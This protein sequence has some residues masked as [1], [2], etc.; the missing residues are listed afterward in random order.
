MNLRYH[1]RE[2]RSALRQLRLDLSAKLGSRR[3]AA[4]SPEEVLDRPAVFVLS[5]GRCGTLFLTRLIEAA[6]KQYW[7]EHNP[8][9]IL[10]F[11]SV[12]AFHDDLD[13]AALGNCF[14]AARY[15]SLRK[16]LLAD[17]TYV[18]TNNRLTVYAGGI[19]DVLPN[20]K[21]I[22]LVRHPGDFVR[23]AMRRDFYARDNS[24]ARGHLS[25][26]AGEAAASEWDDLDRVAKCSWLW[27]E[28]NG[29]AEALHD[30]LDG[31]R[32]VTIKSED[33]F[34]DPEILRSAFEKWG[35]PFAQSEHAN[36]RVNEQKGGD[37]P[38]YSQWDSEQIEALKKWAPLMTKYG[39]DV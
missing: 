30:S 24:S 23:S 27:N 8:D 20:S 39:Y 9:P 21:F 14:L 3:R 25:P 32:V 4:P 31:E 11:E 35:L 17:R 36:R 26:R 37:F 13:A 2:V 5:T 10:N 1:T 16:S 7:V 28:V 34:A 12:R 33:L 29:L 19:A 22:H 38:H 18:E 15:E 6:S